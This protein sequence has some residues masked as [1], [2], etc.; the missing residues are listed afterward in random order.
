[1]LYVCV[2]R[3]SRWLYRLDEDAIEFLDKSICCFSELLRMVHRHI[4]THRDKAKVSYNCCESLILVLRTVS[5][6]LGK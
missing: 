2:H 6:E 5:V 4:C 1:M 3:L